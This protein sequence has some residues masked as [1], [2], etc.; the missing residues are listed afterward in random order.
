M[1]NSVEYEISNAH[2][3]KNIGKKISI[4]LSSYKPRM[5]FFLLINAKMITIVGI[6][7][8]ISSKKSCSAELSMKVFCNP[9]ACF[10]ATR[11]YSFIFTVRKNASFCKKYV[12]CHTLFS[13]KNI[14]LLG[15]Q[16]CDKL[17]T[18]EPILTGKPVKGSQENSAG[19]DQIVLI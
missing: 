9:G 11:G 4:F 2:K 16:R 10:P 8:F 3:Y 14:F 17:L 5:L 13:A 1:L 19:P 6:L 7:T 18:K 15:S 12:M